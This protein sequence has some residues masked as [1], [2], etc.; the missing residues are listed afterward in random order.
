V[1]AATAIEHHHHHLMIC[2]GNAQEDDFYTQLLG[3]K[4]ESAILTSFPMRDEVGEGG[5]GAI[6]DFEL[7]PDL[8]AGSWKFGE[9]VV[10]H[11]AFAVDC[12]DVQ[13]DLEPLEY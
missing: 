11:V 13:D 10:H 12:L 1:G 3:L 6:V 8:A 4:S 5:P 2:T 9:G 7:D